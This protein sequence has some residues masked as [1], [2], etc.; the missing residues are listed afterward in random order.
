MT[1]YKKKIPVSILIAW[2]YLLGTKNERSISLMAKICFI[3]IFV[4]TFSLALIISIMNGFEAA[5]HEK[6]QNIHPQIIMQSKNSKFLNFNQINKVIKKEFSEIEAIAP[7]NSEYVILI[8][9]DDQDISN[10]MVIKGIDP[11]NEIKVNN[12]AQKI[13]FTLGEENK[14]THLLFDNRVILGQKIADQLDIKVGDQLKVLVPQ[15]NRKNIS[16]DKIELIVN[17]L[18]KT[19]ID[20]FDSKLI[21]CNLGFLN[22][23]FPDSDVS[24]IGLKLKKDIDEQSTILKLKKR[25]KLDAF[26]WKDLYPALVSALKLEK[27]VMFFIML[28]ITL[29]ASTNIISLLFM[30]INQKKSDIAILKSMGLSNFKIQQIFLMTSMLISI[31]AIISGLLFSYLAG[32]ILEKY[33]FIELP[34]IYYVDHLPIK[35]NFSIFLIIFISAILIT[36]IASLI[37]INKI[38]QTN[39]SRILKSER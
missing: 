33:S 38:N 5:T 20:E 8:A 4:A 13:T 1:I 23:I 15:K 30:L 26:S 35:M 16:F 19:G 36:L 10:V 22:S 14:L 32:I 31:I 24:Q 27:Y 34:D 7:N 2:R 9:D 3:A 25:F 39:I 29:V 18:I 17:G 6:M 11:E 21:F 37:P 28:L 12:I